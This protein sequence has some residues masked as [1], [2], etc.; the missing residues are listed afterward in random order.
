MAA[1]GKWEGVV[2]LNTFWILVRIVTGSLIAFMGL[3]K[4]LPAGN[5]PRPWHPGMSWQTWVNLVR[6]FAVVEIA[7]GLVISVAAFG[8]VITTLL[9]SVS[10]LALTAYGVVSI[11]KTGHCGCSGVSSQPST[12]TK[13]I[14]RNILIF[15]PAA[16]GSAFGATLLQ[17]PE[18]TESGL[19]SLMLATLCVAILLFPLASMALHLQARMRFKSN[20]GKV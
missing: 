18:T 8:T 5:G 4:L 3:S 15:T 9:A 13:L 7:L 11:I 20:L 10:G 16:A 19:V 6:V 14:V 17:R 12:I 2:D 1:G